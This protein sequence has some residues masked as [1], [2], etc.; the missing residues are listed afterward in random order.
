MYLRRGGR[1]ETEMEEREGRDRRET[2]GVDG[3]GEKLR[4]G[5][6]VYSVNKR[7]ELCLARHHVEAEW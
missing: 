5:K 6:M 7:G 1:E 3:K 2:R 4:R